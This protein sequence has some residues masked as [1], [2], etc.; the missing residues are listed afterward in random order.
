ML[1]ISETASR[2]RSFTSGYAVPNMLD[3]MLQAIVLSQVKLAVPTHVPAMPITAMIPSLGP[4]G[5][6]SM[7]GSPISISQSSIVEKTCAVEDTSA[8][9]TSS[10]F[11][12][13]VLL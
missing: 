1:A 9:T 11:I 8:A 5:F 3:D 6:T 4:G 7:R 2:T 10:C 13:N 12:M